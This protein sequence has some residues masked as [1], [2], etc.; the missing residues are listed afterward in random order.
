MKRI[1]FIMIAVLLIAGCGKK[2]TPSTEISQ[3]DTL[4]TPVKVD[5]IV[6]DV[7]TFHVVETEKKCPNG[8]CSSCDLYYE[9][10]RTPFIPVHDSVNRYIDTLVLH[11]LGDMGS[12]ELKYDLK[13]RA[14]A[15]FASKRE[16]EADDMGTA[17]GWDWELHLNIYR[18]CTELITVNAEWGGYTGGAHPNYNMYTACFF[19]SNGKMVTMK[20]LFTD[21]DAVN[22]IGVKY[23]KKDNQ[24]DPNIDCA[25]QGWDFTDAEFKLNE[26]F[27]I[28]TA[29]ISWQYNSYEIGSYANGAPSVT[30]PIKELDKYLKIKFTDVVIGS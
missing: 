14:Q 9:K 23:F 24:L 28:T 5:S 25:D 20:D 15:F 26:N 22:K 12:D 3:K 11:A 2:A 16:L 30:I 21:L 8:D 1:P 29:S 18:P 27:D 10:I 7:D 19:T 4:P 13:K 17:S 6:F